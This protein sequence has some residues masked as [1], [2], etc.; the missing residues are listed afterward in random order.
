MTRYHSQCSN[1]IDTYVRHHSNPT[2]GAIL[3]VTYKKW[4]NHIDSLCVRAWL[5][6]LPLNTDICVISVSYD[7]AHVHLM[8]MEVYLLHTHDIEHKTGVSPAD[9]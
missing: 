4:I 8:N 5:R 7:F 3:V 2:N 9:I 1:Q 6:R